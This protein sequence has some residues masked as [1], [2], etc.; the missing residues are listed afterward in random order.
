MLRAIGEPETDFIA[1]P[2]LSAD[3]QSVAVFLQRSGDNDIWV[4]ELARNLARRITDGPPADA[5]P[6]WD[7]DGQHVV[8]QLGR[9]SAPRGPARQAVDRREGGAAV[10]RTARA[11]WRCRGRATGSTSCCAA[12]TRRPARTWLPWRRAASRGRCVVA[13]SQA[14][15][16]EGQFSPDGKWVAFVSNDSGRPEVFVQSFPDGRARTQVSTAGGTQVRWSAD[17]KEIF[18]IAPDGKMMAVSIALGGASPDVKL[19]VALFQ[20]HLATGNNVIGNKPQYAVS[21]DGRFLLNTAVES[22]SAPI[23]VSV[24]WMKKLARSRSAALAR[25]HGAVGQPDIERDPI[26]ALDRAR[27]VTLA[28][29]VLRQQDVSGT[30]AQLASAFELNLALAG[31]RDHQLTARRVVPVERVG[32]VG[33]PH[34]Q[35]RHG[36]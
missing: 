11:A 12:T 25:Q 32:L 19:P 13:Q 22:A 9:D 21:R 33:T 18:Y 36:D 2:E 29:G 6:L 23:V 1:S 10:R 35:A 27:L 7:P 15:E 30:E 20:T 16:T 34:L 24:N 3:E 31:K 26:L 14:D 5:H 8:F 17:G 28:G 4:I